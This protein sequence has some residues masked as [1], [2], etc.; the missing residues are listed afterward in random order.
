MESQ[1]APRSPPVP[2]GFESP[3][4]TGF[5]TPIEADS[6]SAENSPG[7]DSDSKTLTDDV[8]QYAKENGRT[9][10]GYRAGT[11]HFPND[12]SETDRL[13]FQYEI[14][15]HCFLGRNYFA[16]LNDP[17]HIL[18]VGT[19]TG[20][21]AIEMGDEFPEAEVQ[22]TDLSPIQPQ[23]VPENVHFFIDDASEEDWALPPSYFDYIHTRVLLGCFEDFRDIIKKAFLYLKPGGYME[24]QEIMSTLYCDDG[25]MPDHF[26]FLQW[27]RDLDEAAMA[28]GR[29]MRIANKMKRWY[30]EAGFVDVEEKTFKLP[31]NTWP[32]DRHLKY[33]GQMQED[34]W[35]SGLG[36]ITMGLFSRMFSWSKTEIEVSFSWT[37]VSTR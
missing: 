34:N 32:R 7:N 2:A 30:K 11:Y 12:P 16:P 4:T 9:Y 31:I 27:N 15:K 33:I 23:E 22:A 28:A 6:P 3:T 36:G 1:R 20:Q 13:D 37:I 21:W 10:H 29:P 26:P 8:Y 5:D 14:L 24:S 25:T 17:K 19:G 35:L 18:D